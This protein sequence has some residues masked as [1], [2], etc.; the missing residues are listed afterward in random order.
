L[1]TYA[2]I[3]NGEPVHFQSGSPVSYDLSN[4]VAVTD[5]LKA[6]G[7]DFAPGETRN[8]YMAINLNE[9]PATL[10]EHYAFGWIKL[11]M[12]MH[13]NKNG[14]ISF[15]GIAGDAYNYEF[16]EWGASGYSLKNLFTDTINNGAY[17]NQSLGYLQ[18]FVW[19][20]EI[21]GT[22]QTTEN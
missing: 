16:H 1:L 10:D 5:K 7:V 20:S 11:A 4:S 14:S 8:I 3:G 2:H 13:K 17:V 18:P 6:L 19:T 21:Q 12:Q 22:I 9:N 15:K